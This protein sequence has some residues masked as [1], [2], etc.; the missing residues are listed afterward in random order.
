MGAAAVAGVV[1]AAGVAA[2]ADATCGGGGP[3]VTA[4][5]SGQGGAVI[6]SVVFSCESWVVSFL[7]WSP[8][9]IARP[10]GGWTLQG[11]ETGV[12]SC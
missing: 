12:L 10:V 6:G 5:A 1:G 8:T 11:L 9:G 4:L 7:E 3:K 2:V